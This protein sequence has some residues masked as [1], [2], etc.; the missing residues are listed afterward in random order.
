MPR[1]GGN[2]ATSREPWVITEE[3]RPGEIGL[4]GGASDGRRNAALLYVMDSGA[5]LIFRK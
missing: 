4:L 1:G 2:P 5:K 3:G